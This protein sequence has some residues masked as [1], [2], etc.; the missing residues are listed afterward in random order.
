METLHA[1]YGRTSYDIEDFQGLV[2]LIYQRDHLT[3]L[4]KLY[5][6]SVVDPNNIVESRYA[7]S[8]KLSEVLIKPL[9]YPYHDIRALFRSHHVAVDVIHSRVP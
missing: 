2:D 9:S 6:W 4:R 1:L 7:I 8:K 5:E 3:L